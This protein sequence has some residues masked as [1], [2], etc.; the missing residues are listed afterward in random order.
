M[1]EVA[2]RFA[3]SHPAVSSAIIGFGSPDAADTGTADVDDSGT[4]GFGDTSTE[5]GPACTQCVAGSLCASVAWYARHASELPPWSPVAPP[6]K[7]MH[8]VVHVCIDTYWP[9]AAVHAAW[10]SRQ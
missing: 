2:V 6:G 4:I 5:T 3:L 8:D 1:A 7:C 9:F 10:T